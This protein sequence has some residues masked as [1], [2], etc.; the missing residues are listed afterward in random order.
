[1]V[2]LRGQRIDGE[3]TKQGRA[4][5]KAGVSQY[6]EGGCN[7]ECDAEGVNK[8]AVKTYIDELHCSKHTT[9]TVHQNDMLVGLPMN[10]VHV[11]FE[12]FAIHLGMSL[13]CPF[14]NSGDSCLLQESPHLTRLAT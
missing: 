14:V 4:A 11:G 1:M 7:D 8:N 12:I 3:S 9:K 2:S 10:K 13:E 6:N 5:F